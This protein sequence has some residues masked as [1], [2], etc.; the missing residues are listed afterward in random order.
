[1]YSCA[2]TSSLK[3]LSVVT[4]SNN[5]SWGKIESKFLQMWVFKVDFLSFLWLTIKASSF[6]LWVS[7]TLLGVCIV[8]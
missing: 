2:A 7:L 4:S 1:M 6:E 5:K 8:V 3:S